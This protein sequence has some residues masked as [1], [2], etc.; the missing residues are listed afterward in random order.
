MTALVPRLPTRA[1]NQPLGR[2]PP[3]RPHS[4]SPAAAHRSRLLDRHPAG[5]RDLPAGVAVPRLLQDAGRVPQRARSGPCPRRFNF[6]NYVEAW[7]TGNIGHVHQQQHHRDVPVAV[8][9]PAVRR[10]RRR[11]RWRSWCGSGRATRCSSLFLAGIMVPAQMIL[12]PLFTV[13]FQTGLTG[14]LLAADHDLH[15]HRAAADACS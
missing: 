3:R 1:A 14:T 11:S 12:L 13:Y 7:T 10:R 9:D 4:R 6:D 8:P 2:D 15:R 5:H